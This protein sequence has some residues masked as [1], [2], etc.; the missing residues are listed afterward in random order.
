MKFVLIYLILS[1]SIILSAPALFGVARTIAEELAA[2]AG[3]IG[4]ISAGAIAS[5]ESLLKQAA[6]HAVTMTKI[7]SSVDTIRFA[8]SV[9]FSFIQK[10]RANVAIE[11]VDPKITE[12]LIKLQ[13]RAAELTTSIHKHLDPIVKSEEISRSMTLKFRK[14]SPDAVVLAPLLDA[15]NNVPGSVLRAINSN[16][17]LAVI[18]HHKNIIVELE[19]IREKLEKAQP[20]LEKASTD[21]IK[22]ASE[23]KTI[24][25]ILVGVLTDIK[26]I[27]AAFFGASSAGGAIAISNSLDKADSTSSASSAPTTSSAFSTPS[28]A[29]ISAIL[30]KRKGLK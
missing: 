4:E 29:P 12:E 26:L 15:A 28:F 27:M 14:L 17:T 24:I 16:P 22:L 23:S 30:S 9:L 25:Q 19:A 18:D 13:T 21:I 7:A 6:S 5:K 11:V 3:K 20:I 8:V 2:K 1:N 10:A